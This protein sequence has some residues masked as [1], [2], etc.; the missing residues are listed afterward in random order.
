MQKTAVK[1][2]EHGE[3]IKGNHMVLVWSS[4]YLGC[5]K[6]LRRLS[7]VHVHKQLMHVDEKQAKCGTRIK[8]LLHG[9][10]YTTKTMQGNTYWT[11]KHL[12][13]R[14]GQTRLYTQPSLG[15]STTPKFLL[16]YEKEKNK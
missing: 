8:T 15:Y 1:N 13:L 5:N 11:S 4:K 6:D 16:M 14:K 10:N 3:N 2:R 7:F 9:G 12:T